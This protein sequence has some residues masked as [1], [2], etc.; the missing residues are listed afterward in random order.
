MAER[1]TR[2]ALEARIDALKA[3]HSGKDFAKAIKRFADDTLD[4]EERDLL[5]EIL[6]ERA[7]AEAAHNEELDDR[8]RHGG[9]MRRQL[10]RLEESAERR[11]RR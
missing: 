6:L 11:P 9:W 2:E 5:R 3:E 10:R 1:W 7:A 4:R 8:I